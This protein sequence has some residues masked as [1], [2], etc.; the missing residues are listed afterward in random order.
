MQ[1]SELIAAVDEEIA[2][3]EQARALLSGSG[4][5][6]ARLGRSAGAFSAGTAQRRLRR[7]SA[8]RRA[9][10]VAAQK[11]P[12]DKVRKAAGQPPAA[13]PAKAVA[14]PKKGRAGRATSTK[15][16]GSRRTPERAAAPTASTPA[17]DASES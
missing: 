3:L 15:K 8:A 12:W 2:R 10:I 14:K 7:I 16:A 6:R 1:P 13:V 4:T 9:R 17:A 5:G 11:A